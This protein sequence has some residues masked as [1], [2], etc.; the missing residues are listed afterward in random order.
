MT[1]GTIEDRYTT[2]HGT[3]EPFDP[4]YGP[5]PVSGGVTFGFKLLLIGGV[6]FSTMQGIFVVSASG[7]GRVWPAADVVKIQLPPPNYH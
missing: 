5:L 6:F 4:K 3:D 7:F 2:H 1:H